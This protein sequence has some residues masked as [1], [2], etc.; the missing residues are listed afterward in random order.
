VLVVTCPC[1]LSLATPTAITVATSLLMKFG[2]AVK[3]GDSIENLTRTTDFIFDKTGTLT[4]GI[5]QLIKIDCINN[6]S[7]E[8]YH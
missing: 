5:P 6:E 4:E 3:H 8:H 7:Q 2:I 1:A